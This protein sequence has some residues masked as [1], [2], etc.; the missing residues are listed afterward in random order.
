[1]RIQ[2]ILFSILAA[3][4]LAFA[5]TAWSANIVVVNF[6][7]GTGQGFDD[8]TPATPVGGNPGT[9]IGEQR[10]N[11]FAV[12]AQSWGDTLQSDVDIYLAAFFQ[13]LFCT[14]TSAVLGSAG[15]T[16]VNANFPGAPLQDVWY[17]GALAD[18]IAGFDIEPV[19]FDMVA[20][21][22]GDIGINPACLIGQSWYNG[23]DHNNDPT[24]EVD[25]LS[26]VMHEFAHGL[27]NL[28]VVSEADGSLL[29]PFP[30]VY[31]LNMYDTTTGLGWGDMTAEERV[32]SQENS[33]NLVWTGQSVTA[34]APMV[35]GPRPSVVALNPKNVAGSYEAQQASYGPGLRENGGTTGK[36]VVVDDGV[37][38]GSDGCE[39]IQNNVSGKIALI[40]RGACSFS[41][42]SAY[43][44]LAGA[45]G[46]IVVNNQPAGLAPMGGSE[47]ITMTIPSV[48]MSNA[49]GSA[50]KAAAAKNSVVK[51]ILDNN[52]K[53]G[54]Q[55]GF[56]RLYAPSPVAPGSSKS[57][58]D[59]S[60][61]PNLLMEPFIN[62]DLA[63]TIFL[64]LTPNLF[65]DIGWTLQ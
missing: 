4:S 49:D 59:T 45:K 31:M 46:V 25:L 3:M 42:K 44:Q 37:G 57:H 51:L 39:P 24:S 61:T 21:F 55:D 64:D 48:G 9:T 15:P 16:R 12:A 26:V 23:F 56:V 18:S 5:S 28:E 2:K 52:F 6:D 7:A 14:E 36:M 1:M 20:R 29:G 22:N 34:D 27:G 19:Y 32:V 38:V 11:V 58:W 17:Y 43:A 60:A 10:L 8:P 35:L 65:E 50:L 63:P 47:L 30:D 41:L 13:P 33:G 40:D 53:A 62:D 54:M